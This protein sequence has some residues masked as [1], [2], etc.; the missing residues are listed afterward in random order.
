[1][2]SGAQAAA[3]ADGTRGAGL[4][5]SAADL[6]DKAMSLL[7]QAELAGDLRTALI[8]VREAARCLELIA[9]LS[10]EIDESVHL[11]IAFAPVLIE[12]QTNVLAA[13]GAFPD[14]RRAVIA[15]LAGIGSGPAMI[16]H[17][18]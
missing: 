10:G 12:L 8:G 5:E 1:M 2:L 14:A 16:E 6:R 3:E 4:M 11:N 18:S 15:A 17:A 9:K 13:L 7:H